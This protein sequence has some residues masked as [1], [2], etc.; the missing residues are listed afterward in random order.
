MD[1]NKLLSVEILAMGILLFAIVIIGVVILIKMKPL[2]DFDH[3]KY[4]KLELKKTP[5]DVARDTKQDETLGRLV[6]I[7]TDLER[8]L[9]GIAERLS[10]INKRQDIHY[11]F[12]KEAAINAAKAVVWSD[13]GAPF[14]EVI[15]SGL[16]NLMLGQNGNLVGRMKEVIK[17]FGAKGTETYQSSLNR[18]VNANK[19]KLGDRFYKSIAEIEQGI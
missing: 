10:E 11:Q 15:Q 9:G 14:E 6:E 4:G 5:Q 12:T 16:F 1:I 18:F 3:V 19:D 8:R 7:T 13:K 2:K 17:G